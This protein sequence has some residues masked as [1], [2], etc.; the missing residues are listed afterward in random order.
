LLASVAF[1]V[2]AVVAD[3]K[4]ALFTLIFIALTCPTY[5]VFVRKS[6]IVAK[7]R[8]ELLLESE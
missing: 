1:L 8:E 5:F 2:A 6:A 4:D 7:Q 3:L